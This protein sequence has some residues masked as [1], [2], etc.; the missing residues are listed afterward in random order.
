ML[1]ALRTTVLGRQPF[2][3]SNSLTQK[4]ATRISKNPPKL[5]PFSR[6]L[7]TIT[8][9]RTAS[10]LRD[11]QMWR[12]GTTQTSTRLLSRTQKR[13]FNWSWSRRAQSGGAKAEEPLSLS[14]RLKKLGREYGWSAFGVY[15]ALSV[16]DFPFCFLL[17]KWAAAIEEWVVSN[18][19]RI[20][21]EGVKQQVNEWRAAWRGT[22]KDIEKEEI[23]DNHISEGVE[24]VGWG[25]EEAQQ[26]HKADASLATQ[27]AL[28]YAIHK[29]FIF[30]RVPL[31]A[32]VTPKVVKVLRSWGW[33]I[34]KRKPKKPKT[35]KVSKST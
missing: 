35:P 15:M 5:I 26:A 11:S 28:A 24:K 31:T 22:Y 30:I 1:R 20:I 19:K 9:G 12:N 33:Q 29:S 23:G 10:P 13:N 25:V 3:T 8:K 17:V 6:S 16:L 7:Q 18:F 14:G 34:G 21:P 27:L 32:A 2:A 4:L